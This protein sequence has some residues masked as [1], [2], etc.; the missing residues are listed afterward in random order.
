MCCKAN[1]HI[2]MSS[3]VLMRFLGPHDTDDVSSTASLHFVRP[4][5]SVDR[6]SFRENID[7]VLQLGEIVPDMAPQCSLLLG[8]HALL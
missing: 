7:R 4:K 6:S 1:F 5:G 2:I 8:I 3:S